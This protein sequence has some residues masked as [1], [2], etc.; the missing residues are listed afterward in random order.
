MLSSNVLS[1]W[2]GIPISKSVE[3]LLLGMF[4]CERNSRDRSSYWKEWPR[5][6]YANSF[7]F[8]VCTPIENLLKPAF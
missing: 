8:S 6:S 2:F 1:R 5:P 3:T 4:D 7:S